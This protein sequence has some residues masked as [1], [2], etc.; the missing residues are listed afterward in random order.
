MIFVG[1]SL[2]S[3][4]GQH[5]KKLSQLFPGAEYY[6]FGQ[7]IPETD[8]AFLFAIP[9]EQTLQCIP[10]IKE[11]AKKVTCMTVCE[12]DPV[13]EDYGKLCA[14]FDKVAVPSEF[15]RDVLSRQFPDTEF[16]IIHAHIPQR[17]YTFYHI[18]NIAD[19]RK[20]FSKILE[21]FVRLNKP[22]ARL[23]VKATCNRPV[24]IKL[25]NVEV[26]NGL[27]SDRD[28]DV[29]HG[30]GDCYV[31]FSKSEG[32]GMGAV[33]AAMRDKPVITTEYGGSSEYIRTPYMIHC[34]TQ[35]LERDDFL[36][37]K[38]TSWGKPSFDQLLAFMEDAYSKRLQYMDHAHTKQLV[39]AKNVLS[40]LLV[41]VE[42]G[43][44]D[45]PH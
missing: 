5:C 25:P 42:R 38:G 31:G 39:S 17:P 37:V 24:E 10:A 27:V 20:Q 41:D 45:E 26:I 6:Q 21:A 14:L 11:K 1:Y 29:I 7:D 28:M 12:T 15:C 2:S 22:D 3:G 44:H 13:H 43:E 33:E 9:V 19:D 40:E 30:L 35:Q 34:E 36:F 8:H 32:V 4:L 16:Y 23:L 18:G